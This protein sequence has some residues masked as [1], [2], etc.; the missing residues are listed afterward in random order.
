MSMIHIKLAIVDDNQIDAEL[1]KKEIEIYQQEHN[2]SVVFTIATF[3]R[4]I[5]FIDPFDNSYDAV[6]LDIDMPIMSGMECA[7]RIR[8]ESSD[9]NIIFVTNYASLAIDGYGVGA[10]DFVVKPVKKADV[11]RA[12]DKITISKHN[13]EDDVK[14]LIKVKNGYQTIRINEI[15]YIEVSIH[16]V[17]YYTINGVYKTRESLKQIEKNINSDKFAK[18]SSAYLINLDYVDSIDKDDVKIDGQKIKIARTRKKDFLNA[19]LNNYR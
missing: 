17:Y 8:S 1:L 12:L 3:N 2:D 5:N 4:G 6:F 11:F 10:L 19:F 16:D 14:I 13:I 7:K 9:M 18:C 15:K